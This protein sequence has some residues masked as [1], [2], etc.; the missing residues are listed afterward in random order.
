MVF[1]DHYLKEKGILVTGYG[2]L[3]SFIFIRIIKEYLPPLDVCSS[4]HR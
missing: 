4:P 2:T 1:K 3:L